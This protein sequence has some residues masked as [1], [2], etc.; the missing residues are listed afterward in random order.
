MKA[1]DNRQQEGRFNC[2]PEIQ[3]RTRNIVN[4]DFPAHCDLG[5]PNPAKAKAEILAYLP[6]P[7]S[8]PSWCH[9]R[10]PA[11][12]PNVE[13]SDGVRR[14]ARWLARVLPSSMSSTGREHQGRDVYF[15]GYINTFNARLSMHKS[16][17]LRHSEIG[18][19]VETKSPNLTR[20]WA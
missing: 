14:D 19:L 13:A 6:Q 9:T 12:W 4:S 11:L 10:L 1:R 7:Q 17:A 2:P 8:R 5:G 18:S 16:K 20:P 15:S 3:V